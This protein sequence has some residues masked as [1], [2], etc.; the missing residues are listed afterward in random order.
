M[1]IFASNIKLLRKRR[2][3]TQDDVAFALDMK[4]STLSGYENEV[5]QPG[6]EALLQLSNYYGVSVD[7]L[8]K[9]DLSGLRESELSQLEK[10]YDVFITGS[11]I[12][13]LATTVDSGNNENVELVNQKASAGYRTGFADPEYIKVLPTFHMPFLSKEKKYRTFQINGDSML[14]IPDGSW[15]TGEFVQNW[16]LIRDGQP[17]I[18]LT[19]ND[20]IMFKVVFNL[21]RTESRLSLHSLNP[22]YEP[23]DVE[24]KDVREVWKFVHYISSAMPE[25]N[26]PK[27]DLTA[28]VAA[29]KKDMEKLKKQVASSTVLRLPF[30]DE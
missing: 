17:Y 20:G 12:R 21:I 30:N 29:L 11:K 16:N 22:L 1:N 18:I 25:P 8:L 28:T 4:R 19:L 24:I 10:G 2:G 7:T 26:L 23:Y 13:V 5:A 14:P 3:R 6:I 27:E 15:V 9:I